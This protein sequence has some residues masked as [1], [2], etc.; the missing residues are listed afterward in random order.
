MMVN[1]DTAGKIFCFKEKDKSRGKQEAVDLKKITLMR[2]AEIIINSEFV[3]SQK[4]QF[5]IKLL[6]PSETGK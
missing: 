4:G 2:E 1:C 6:L 5:I 3:I